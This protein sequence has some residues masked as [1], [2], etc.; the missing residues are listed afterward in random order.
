[1]YGRKGRIG[2]GQ[3]RFL[4]RRRFFWLSFIAA[5][6][7][8]LGWAAAIEPTLLRL[9]SEELASPHWPAAQP[10]LKIVLLADLHVGAPHVSLARVDALV[11]T[12]NA[13]EPDLVLLAGDYVA[14]VLGG[15]K[16]SHDG[17]ARSLGALRARRRLCRDGQ[18]RH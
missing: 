8:A 13:A 17:M 6:L 18:R 12:A 4:R 3:V 16:V 7:L 5:G 1:M 11:A 14:R 2:A 9:R 10:K 15:R